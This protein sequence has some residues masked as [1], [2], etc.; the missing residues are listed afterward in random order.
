MCSG[1]DLKKDAFLQGKQ[2]NS[3]YKAWKEQVRTENE[4]Y[5]GDVKVK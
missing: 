1:R 5:A 4:W 3:S 2:R